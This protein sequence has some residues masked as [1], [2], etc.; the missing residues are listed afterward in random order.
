[1]MKT[2]SSKNYILSAIDSNQSAKFID[3]LT[4]LFSV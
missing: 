4:K 2:Y 1:M 3:Y